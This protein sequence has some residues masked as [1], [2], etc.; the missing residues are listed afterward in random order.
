MFRFAVLAAIAMAGAPLACGPAQAQAA[1]PNRPVKIIVPIGPGGSYDM[2]GRHVADALSKRTGHAFFVENKPGAGTVVGTQAAAQSEPDGYTLVIGGLSNMAFNSAL[3]SKLGYDPRRD[4]VPVALIYRFGYVMVARRDMPQAALQ[5]IVAAA[6]ADPGSISV[7]TAGVGTGQQ[8][9]AA[10]FM[11][12]SGVKLL[13]VPYKGSP[14]AFTDLLA[15]RVDLFFDSIAAGLPYVQSGQAKGIAVLSSRRSPLAPDVPTMSEAGVSGL[16]VDSWLGIFVPA[17]TP[18]EVIAKLRH[19][20]RAAVPDL[21]ERFEKSGGEA[22][23]VPDDK[24]DGFV[25]SEYETW[26]RLIRDAGIKLD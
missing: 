18:P 19:E 10:A 22:W 16:D 1:Y 3:Y 15:G 11:R 24:L 23:D 5:D 8:L 20:I 13:E 2:V 7:A 26:T 25:A 14:P 17:K 9:V 4:F 21:K 6:K 12:A